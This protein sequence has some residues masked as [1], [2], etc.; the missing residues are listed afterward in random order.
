MNTIKTI[1]TATAVA[2]GLA[3]CA[4]P[5]RD[6]PARQAAVSP[7][8]VSTDQLQRF[9]NAARKV[10]AISPG[11]GAE[12]TGATT[13][14][15]GQATNATFDEVNG[16]KAQA[17]W[18]EG[19]TVQEFNAI[20][21]AVQQDPALMQRYGE[22]MRGSGSGSMGSGSGSMGGGSMGGGSMGGGSTGGGT[23]MR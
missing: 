15:T 4:S 21:A 3:A 9:A 16:R 17:V 19:L 7:Q 8:S 10:N 6:M 20:N 23:M 12:T 22:L 1:L 2:A 11:T 18:S 5:Q 14:S 13:T